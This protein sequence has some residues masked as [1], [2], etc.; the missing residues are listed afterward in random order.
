MFWTCSNELWD[1]DQPLFG[2]N[3]WW[4]KPLRWKE[5]FLE[6]CTMVLIIGNPTHVLYIILYNCTY[7]WLHIY[8]YILYNYLMT[9]IYDYINMIIYI[10]DIYMTW[11]D[12]IYTHISITA[13]KRMTFPWLWPCPDGS[14]RALAVAFASRRALADWT[15]SPQPGLWPTWG[16]LLEMLGKSW[17]NH[18]PSGYLT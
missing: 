16:N 15:C 11:Y 4:R 6:R 5:P 2:K 13:P 14:W 7:I 10:Y 9:Y 18:L 8:I 12:I 1:E 3:R 17:E